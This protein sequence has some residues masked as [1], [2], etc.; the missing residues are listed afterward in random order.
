MSIFCFQCEGADRG[1]GCRQSGTCGKSEDLAHLQNLLIAW[2]KQ[3]ALVAVRMRAAGNASSVVDRFL[4]DSLY[5]TTTGVNFDQND[6][7]RRI[8]MADRV[9]QLAEHLSSAENV[10]WQ[11]SLEE[12]AL[13]PVDGLSPEDVAGQIEQ[14]REY[15]VSARLNAGDA[16]VVGLQECLLAGVKGAATFLR[17]AISVAQEAYRKLKFEIEGMQM[18]IDAIKARDVKERPRKAALRDEV[19]TC[20]KL[21]ASQ[22]EEQQK[23]LAS[24]WETLAFLASE[25][26][27]ATELGN[28]LTSLG[29]LNLDILRLLEWAR[30]KVYGVPEPAVVRTTPVAGKCI[31]VS[32][33]DF[34][35][36]LHLLEATRN[37]D[38]NI[39]THGELLAAHS[40]PAFR[41]FPHLVGHY[42]T[43]WQ[44]QIKEFGAFPGAILVTSDHLMAPDE[45][46]HDYIFTAGELRMPG[47]R[48]LA[49]KNN[50]SFDF[51]PL[52][53]ASL[54][55]SGFFKTKS[56][57]KLTV[58]FGV[59]AI[60]KNIDTI[61]K[62]MEQ[63]YLRN[64]FVIG[65]C[66]TAEG[67]DSYFTEFV[68]NLPPDCMILAFG[69][70][71]FRFNRLELAPL[72]S[73]FPRLFDLGQLEDA[74]GVIELLQFL[75]KEFGLDLAQ[76]PLAVTLA[77]SDQKSIAV[78]L[79]FLTLKLRGLRL[80]ATRPAFLTPDAWAR[81]AEQ[82]GLN[83]VQSPQEDLD[84]L[85]GTSGGK[86]S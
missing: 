24:L 17:E 9:Y 15:T 34:A 46:Y 61:R 35:L 8:Y 50:G 27:D 60:K 56:I 75:S 30:N 83:F 58:G 67:D 22:Q 68:S 7:V 3:V 42:G 52:I 4:L 1:T 13:A 77:W 38:I 39:F 37:K 44:K 85:L 65:G 20:K 40:Y 2:C 64:F 18:A 63:R 14:G 74:V 71:K 69:S 73:G 11:K 26:N 29:S 31:L 25:P 72:G 80:G 49:R 19:I 54:D 28:A 41:K 79:S 70:V 10:S 76:L 16:T 57:E 21:L 33:S 12:Q 59:D 78:L 84:S 66:D 81:L 47:V 86:R 43:S 48:E 62:S 55:S 82:F 36:L 32:G 51:N 45:S 5:V 53:Q 6:L 23:M